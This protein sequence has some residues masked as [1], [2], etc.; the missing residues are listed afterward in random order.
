M[1]ASVHR[2]ELVARHDPSRKRTGALMRVDFGKTFGH[3]DCHPW[4]EFGDLP[5]DRQ[6]SSWAEDKPTD[7]ILESFACAT[8]DSADRSL[9]RS[10]FDGLTIPPSHALI[11]DVLADDLDDRLLELGVAGFD[12]LKLK[13]G[14]HAGSEVEAIARLVPTL[15]SLG[16]KA[17]LDF[18]LRLT[19]RQACSFVD[20]LL[21]T[22]GLDWLDWLEDPCPFSRDDWRG[23][24]DRFGVRLALDFA[25]DPV[26]APIEG[27]ADVIVLKPA[28]RS[29]WPVLGRAKELEIP[30]CVTSYLDHPVGQTYAALIAADA[31]RHGEKLETCGLLSHEVY[32][33]GP[34]SERIGAAGPRMLPP[35]GT[36]LGFDDLLESLTWEPLP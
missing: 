3:A 4:P 25:A 16:M 28:I 2:Y 6:L 13:L 27:A 20:T 12:R 7:L 34:F 1:I 32:E 26:R 19:C 8:W 21:T 15:R 33:P 36:G 23:I 10:A 5:L 9:G 11:P 24:R 14:S 29:P 31:Q 35:A 17:R 22:T 30:V 18:N